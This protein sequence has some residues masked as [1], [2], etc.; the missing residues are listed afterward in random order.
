MTSTSPF[1]VLADLLD[2]P[3]EPDPW[4]DLVGAEAL[5]DQ[6]R[7]LFPA[8]CSSPFGEHHLQLWEWVRSIRLGER[9]DPLVCIWP[10]GGAKSTSAELA[11]VVLGGR[12]VRRY[13]LYV[14]GIQE[15]ADDHVGNVGALLES[16]SVERVWP[17]MAERRLGKYGNSKGWRVNRLRTTSGFTLDAVGLDTAARGVKL[18][19]ARPD[20]ICHEVGTEILDEGRWGKVEAHPGLLGLRES[21]GMEVVLWGV[22]MP[23]VVTPEHRYW[24]RRM[25]E[26]RPVGVDG[27]ITA[28]DIEYWSKK[29]KGNGIAIGWQVPVDVQP[30]QSVVVG[31]SKMRRQGVQGV[32]TH[33]LQ[34]RAVPE[35]LSD[36]DWWWLVGLWWGDGHSSKGGGNQHALGLAI[37]DS[38]PEI[39]D[40]VHSVL[41]KWGYTWSEQQKQGCRSLVFSCKWMFLWTLN[42]WRRIVDGE[43]RPGQKCP[44]LWVESIACE[45]QASL[46]R[47][48]F[49][50][51][52]YVTANEVRLTSV[53]LHGLMSARRMLARLGIPASVRQG[54]N[55]SRSEHVIMGRTCSQQKR[56]D[57]RVRSGAGRL[58]FDVPAITRNSR[59]SR[60]WLDGGWLWSK[61]R[62]ARELA[63]PRKFAPI[64][65]RVGTY[66][67]WFGLSHN[68]IDDVD[69]ETDSPATTEKRIKVLTRAILPAGSN[70]LAVLSIQNLVHADSVFA[71]LAGRGDQPADFLARRTVSGPIP[72]VEGLVTE[73]EKTGRRIIVGGS[74]T[75]AG[76]PLET[77]QAQI[78]DWGIS[79]FLAE[80]QHEVS[81]RKGKMFDHLDY[82][83]CTWDQVPPLVRV[84]VWV[85]PAVTATD[86]SD[87]QG[88]QAD[89]ISVDG[90][91]YRLRSWEQRTTPEDALARAIRWAYELGADHVGVET[92][93]GGDTWRSVYLRAIEAVLEANPSWRRLPRL[94]FVSDKAGA[95]AGPKAHRASKMLAD[96]E[97]G[98]RIVHV[99]G[100]HEVLER[101]LT[102]FP[103]FKP[104]DLVDAT[105]WSW[106]DLREERGVYTPVAPTGVGEA[107]GWSPGSEYASA[108]GWAP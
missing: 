60:V 3:V 83:R 53:S 66:E 68:C 108:G 40:R 15:S 27:W 85:D 35:E 8:Y 50:A 17:Q 14:S 32:E 30:I 70:D 12:G 36:P 88:I 94:G 38:Q 42:E 11:C 96:Y 47:G 43:Y 56:W 104:L 45:H 98:G 10:R 37:A 100:T 67:T 81:E 52:G 1:S 26:G 82:Q 9:P 6:L 44:P 101:A 29:K 24:G 89:G 13:G 5:V 20:F 28:A 55:P 91:I 34:H 21:M 105:Y 4:A 103:R 7:S 65:T 58:G 62:S 75:W 39:R 22:P 51:D 16:A 69:T 76:Q 73:A 72:A 41:T 19:D 63:E 64:R 23:E 54:P 99:I 31:Q 107:G 102:R 18:E 78:D 71:R 80:A 79:A 48:Y 46:L 92:D 33:L 61:V 95:G 87:S 77:C 84:V 97:R 57:L 25:Y 2:P 93:Q 86:D 74:A 59:P 90:T 49:D 106:Q